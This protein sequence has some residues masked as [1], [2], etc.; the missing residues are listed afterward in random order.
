MEECQSGF[1]GPELKLNISKISLASGHV[2]TLCNLCFSRIMNAKNYGGDLTMDILYYW[3]KE[4][5]NVPKLLESL[6]NDCLKRC[7][8]IQFV[9][10]ELAKMRRNINQNFPIILLN[11]DEKDKFIQVS[12]EDEN[13]AQSILHDVYNY[14]ERKSIL[15]RLW[16]GC[17]SAAKECRKIFVSEL[18]PDGTPKKEEPYTPDMRAT[19][20]RKII[21][22]TTNEDPIYNAGVEAAAVWE[23]IENAAPDKKMYLEGIPNL[24]SSPITKYVKDKSKTIISE[25]DVMIS[26]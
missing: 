9:N 6:K 7:H 13:I 12:E 2:V 10:D 3:A 20:F 21:I 23:L 1:H 14:R 19:S 5:G 11:P 26:G 22:P 16:C 17:L 8:L 25:D 18:N 15:L 4:Y 24:D